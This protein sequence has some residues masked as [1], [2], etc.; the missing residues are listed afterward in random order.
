MTHLHTIED[1]DKHF[2]IDPITKKIQPE[3][4]EKNKLVRYDHNS[5]RYTFEMERMIEGHDMSLCDIVQIHYINVA[6]NKQTKNEDVYEVKDLGL[7][8][9]DDN[10]IA[11]TW[12]ISRNA[13]MLD[14]ILTFAI[15]FACS[16]GDSIDY[17]LHTE[18]FSSISI[19]NTIFNDGQSIVEEYSDIL[20]Q[21]KQE[22]FSIEGTIQTA[23]N[24]S[25]KAISDSKTDALNLINKN[26]A[27]SLN[28]IDANRTSTL[29]DI[30]TTSSK[31]LSAINSNAKDSLAAMNENRDSSLTA[32]DS[33]K[34]ES[35]NAISEE[36]AKQVANL[37]GIVNGIAQDSTAQVI[38][39]KENKSS[40]LL[41]IIAEAAGKAGSLNG[42]GLE[43]GLNDSVVISYT[44]P[45]SGILE[46]TAMFP[47][48]TTLIKI[49]ESLVSINKSLKLIAM[50][51]G[52]TM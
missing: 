13:T 20:N 42:F 11:F 3:N 35:L 31:A 33:A 39:E 30:E 48:D 17:E 38:L 43:K 21:W 37:E 24:E 10:K 40:E 51:N 52:V 5:E 36:G 22:L 19:S 49:K 14:G 6:S 15:R 45:E 1:H 50:R 44:D 29:L 34:S 7:L 16:N 41:Q 27:D 23:K 8:E 46:G 18:I 32:M 2:V 25:L 12:L 26:R 28:A 47:R 9:D 4:P